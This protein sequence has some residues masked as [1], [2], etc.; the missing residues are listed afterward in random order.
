MYLRPSIFV[1][2]RKVQ[3]PEHILAVAFV[4]QVT[5]ERACQTSAVLLRMPC[6]LGAAATA[7][8]KSLGLPLPQLCPLLVWCVAVSLAVCR[9]ED[10]IGIAA[11]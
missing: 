11:V 9:I 6:T 2:V 3:V 4:L 7:P 8:L 10:F 1:Q 5:Q